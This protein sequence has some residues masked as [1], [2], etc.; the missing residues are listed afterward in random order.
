[1]HSARQRIEFRKFMSR[2][3]GQ[4]LIEWKNDEL[5]KAYESQIAA[6]MKASQGAH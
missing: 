4:A 3:R 5:K 6:E 2:V 1:V